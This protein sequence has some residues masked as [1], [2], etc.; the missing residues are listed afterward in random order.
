MQI[1][2]CYSGLLDLGSGGLLDLGSGG[3]LDPGSG[4]LLGYL[5]GSDGLLGWFRWPS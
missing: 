1:H 2:T 3:L 5:A 4:G